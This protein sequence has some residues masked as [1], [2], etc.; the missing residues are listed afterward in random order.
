MGT[1]REAGLVSSSNVETMVPGRPVKPSLKM[2]YPLNN[3]PEFYDSFMSL[4]RAAVRK[5]RRQRKNIPDEVS[6]PPLSSSSSPPETKEKEKEV[7]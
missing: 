7:K 5:S 1:G 3:C 4:L 2:M 6:I